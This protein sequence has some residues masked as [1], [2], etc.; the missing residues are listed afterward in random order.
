[1][2]YI[3]GEPQNNLRVCV[4]LLKNRDREKNLKK[5]FL[6]SNSCVL[7]TLRFAV[8]SSAAGQSRN[9]TQ[10]VKRGLTRKLMKFFCE[11]EISVLSRSHRGEGSSPR[12]FS[13]SPCRRVVPRKEERENY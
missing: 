3:F 8:H 2:G 9:E 12:D 1:M 6:F 11:G 10:L 5:D 4:L 7:S 13:S